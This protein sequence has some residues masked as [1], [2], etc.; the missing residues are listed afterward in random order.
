[1]RTTSRV[2]RLEDAVPK[3]DGRLMRLAPEDHVPSEADLSRRC[4]GCHILVL[5]KVVVTPERFAK[6]S[7][8]GSGYKSSRALDTAVSSCHN[9]LPALAVAQ[10]NH[11]PNAG[12]TCLLG[13]IN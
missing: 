12:A 8:R 2:K 1:M 5:E 10:R 9:H 11:L 3:C 4:G 6:R 13:E 7:R